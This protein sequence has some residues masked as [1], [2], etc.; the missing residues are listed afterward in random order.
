MWQHTAAVAASQVAQDLGNG[1][2]RSGVGTSAMV[3]GWIAFSMLVMVTLGLLVMILSIQLLDR[4]TDE[5]WL[6][7][8]LAAT[9]LTTS[10][11]SRDMYSTKNDYKRHLGDWCVAAE[12]YPLKMTN[13]YIWTKS[14]TAFQ[15]M[16]WHWNQKEKTAYMF[17]L[18]HVVF[19]RR[20]SED[21]WI[22]CTSSAE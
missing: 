13:L 5:V 1:S 15:R 22:A 4:L 10:R 21:C 6:L 20:V 7:T 18:R 2:V 3:L 14:E 12:R 19:K 9:E 16:I 11:T 17:R 8:E